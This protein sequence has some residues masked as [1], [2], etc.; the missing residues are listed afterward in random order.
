MKP[1]DRHLQHRV[2]SRVY[3]G[4]GKELTAR[5]RESLRRALARS[6][7]N[8]AVFEKMEHHPLYAEAFAR[9]AAETREQIKML[10]QMLY[11]WQ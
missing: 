11:N 4:A 1:L 7:E 6:R 3:D 2:W 10:Q 8:L 5:Q 9:M